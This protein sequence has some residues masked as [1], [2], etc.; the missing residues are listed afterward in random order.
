MLLKSYRLD[1]FNKF[2][3]ILIMQGKP[4]FSKETIIGFTIMNVSDQSGAILGK[5]VIYGSVVDEA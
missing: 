2:L 3:Y 1:Y 5:P 4:T